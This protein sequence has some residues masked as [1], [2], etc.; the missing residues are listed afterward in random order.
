M[1][2]PRILFGTGNVVKYFPLPQ[3]FVMC[4]CVILSNCV[5]PGKLLHASCFSVRFMCILEILFSIWEVFLEE[6]IDM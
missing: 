6:G 1:P 5:C 4:G 3:L 2:D